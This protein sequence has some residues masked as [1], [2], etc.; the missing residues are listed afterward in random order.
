M[1]LDAK[2]H[3]VAELGA[4]EDQDEKFKFLI[5][6]G[7]EL[8][9]MAPEKKTDQFLVKGCMSQ[10]WLHPELKD[11]RIYFEVDSDAGPFRE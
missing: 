6:K 4:I 5:A 3:I 11:G 1:T 8:P 10:L 7:R 2:N 9:P